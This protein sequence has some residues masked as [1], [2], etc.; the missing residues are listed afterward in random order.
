MEDNQFEKIM[1][2]TAD[3]CCPD[4]MFA[5]KM[6]CRLWKKGLGI[7]FTG[8]HAK[9]HF[10]GATLVMFLFF[11]G[12]VGTYAYASPD[13]NV[14][15]PLFAVKQGLET[16]EGTLAF[17]PEQKADFFMR[18]AMRRLDE[19]ERMHGRLGKRLE[20]AN[21]AEAAQRTLEMINLEMERS[22]EFAGGEFDA[23]RAEN[24]VN[25][26]E[27]RCAQIHER[28][29]GLPPLQNG[30]PHISALREKMTSLDDATLEKLEELRQARQTVMQARQGRHN[31]VMLRFLPPPPPESGQ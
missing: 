30:R 28:I 11:G 14:S 29:K 3:G 13:V 18:Q 10:A 24:M 22:F 4:R 9:M 31:R 1:K 25:R 8:P 27:E 23:E 12:G 7:Y 21:E 17:S 26:M 5:A 19:A 16:V 15:H 20:M 6:R 2:K